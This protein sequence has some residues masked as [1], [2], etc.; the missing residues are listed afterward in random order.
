MR[1]ALQ[2][3]TLLFALPQAACESHDP[4]RE[5][6]LSELETHWAVDAAVGD[7]Q[8]IAPVV[9]FQVKSRASEPLRTVQATATFR[10]KGEEQLDWGSAWERVTLPSKPLLPGQS[11]AVVLKSDGRYYSSGEPETFFQHKQFKDAKVTVY[12]R[13][14]SSQ[15]VKFAES[16]VERRIG[17]KAL[18]PPK[19]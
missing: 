9:R 3:V 18:L 15:W 1:R 10:R 14:G 5:L 2:L 8:Y 4:Q 12:L 11:V 6:L 19:P 16:D 17:T 13:V 7:R